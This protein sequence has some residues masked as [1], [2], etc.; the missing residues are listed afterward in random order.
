MSTMFIHIKGDFDWA[1]ASTLLAGLLA[2]LGVLL[3]LLASAASTRRQHRIQIY[4]DAM[5]AVSDYLEGPYRVMR[6]PD[7]KE[8]RFALTQ[9]ISSI[10]SRIDGHLVLVQMSA[11]KKVFDAYDEYVKAA[12]EEAGQQ[13]REQWDEDALKRRSHMHAP[14]RFEQPKSLAAR[15]KLIKLMARDS[16]PSWRVWR[17]F[18]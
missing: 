4:G 8:L 12:R 17:Y 1:A 5:G 2:A 6:C 9:D 10:Q 7:D 3:G 14:Q 16:K 15:A 11:P 13:M 18:F